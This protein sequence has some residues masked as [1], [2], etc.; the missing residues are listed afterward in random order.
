[1]EKEVYWSRFAEEFDAMNRYVAGEDS[2]RAICSLL[3]E[4]NLTGDVLE[5]GCGSGMY[6]TAAAGR[7]R[8][9]FATDLSDEMLQAARK[10]LGGLENAAVEK[11]NCK[12]LTYTDASFDSVLMINLLHIIDEPEKVLQEAKRVL[13][14]GGRAFVVSFTTEGLTVFNKLGMVYR[15]LK[16]YGKPPKTARTL[17]V[18]SANAMVE[19]AGFKVEESKLIGGKS[20]AVFVKSNKGLQ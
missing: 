18:S 7:A 13:K 11:Q 19:E 3:E 1:M 20:K 6:T 10:N 4:S 8:R 5:M 12:A 14:P 16:T 17:T 9:V 15:Y 2:I